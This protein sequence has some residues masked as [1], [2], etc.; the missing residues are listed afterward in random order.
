MQ[1]PP[2]GPSHCWSPLCLASAGTAATQPTSIRSGTEQRSGFGGGAEAGPFP[3]TAT[4]A[5]VGGGPEEGASAGF[6]PTATTTART[7]APRG[8]T[9]ASESDAAMGTSRGAAGTSF[10]GQGR[11]NEEAMGGGV[12]DPTPIESGKQGA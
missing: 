7:S 3:A 11:G 9:T 2:G 8:L 12:L 5:P 6:V 10:T 1:L 4:G